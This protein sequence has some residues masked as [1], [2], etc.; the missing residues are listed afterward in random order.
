MNIQNLALIFTPVIFHDFNQTDENN[1]GDWSP[2]D[3]FEDLILHYELLFPIAEESARRNNE[4][5]LALALSGKSPYS[6][7]SQSNLLYLSKTALQTPTPA[8]TNNMLLTQPMNPSMLMSNNGGPESPGGPLSMDQQYSN[9]YPPN[10]P[11]IINAVPHQRLGSLQ[12]QQQQPYIAAGTRAINSPGV[13][14]ESSTR[15]VP[16]RYQSESISNQYQQQLGMNRSTSDTTVMQRGSSMSNIPFNENTNNGVSCNYPGPISTSNNNSPVPTKGAYDLGGA[17]I[18]LLTKRDSSSLLQQQQGLSKP[19]APPRHDSLR[20]SNPCPQ[21]TPEKALIL[22][23]QEKGE[24]SQPFTNNTKQ[25]SN[26]P[27]QITTTNLSEQTQ[28]QPQYYSSGLHQDYVLPS[29]PDNDFNALLDCYSPVNSDP[30][31]LE[32]KPSP[33]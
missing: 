17:A 32:P 1:L 29:G 28:Q 30:P 8:M 16:P 6:Q 19:G 27:P 10:L 14:N 31:S 22:T 24:E 12:Q 4:H 11:S 23:E 33:T 25:M 13:M 26:P 20:R 9:Q 7:F 18:P 5:K 15:I 2:E 3:L 21:N